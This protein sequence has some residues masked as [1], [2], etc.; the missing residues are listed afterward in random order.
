MGD[1]AKYRSCRGAFDADEV[2]DVIK[3]SPGIGFFMSRIVAYPVAF[4]GGIVGMVTVGPINGAIQLYKYNKH[5]RQ[6]QLSVEEKLHKLTDQEFLD[7]IKN[8]TAI[9]CSL[10]WV[11]TEFTYCTRQFNKYYSGDPEEPNDPNKN[12]FSPERLLLDRLNSNLTNSMKIKE[13]IDYVNEN[14]YSLERYYF[15]NQLISVLDSYLAA[16][17]RKKL[18]AI[19]LGDSEK[20]KKTNIYRSFFSSEICDPNV[21]GIVGSLLDEKYVVKEKKQLQTVDTNESKSAERKNIHRKN[22]ERRNIERKKSNHVPATQ[23]RPCHRFFVMPNPSSK[24]KT[25]SDKIKSKSQ[26]MG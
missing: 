5:R 10:S 4:V 18:E 9:P 13:F 11:S 25:E 8:V 6:Q 14:N 7:M 12:D 20:G 2:P 19:F 17:T 21:M 22:I 23:V 16:A 24:Q 15:R 3:K 1:S 26:R